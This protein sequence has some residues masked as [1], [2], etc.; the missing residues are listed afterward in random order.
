MVPLNA[1]EILRQ[2]ATQ[3]GFDAFG[4]AP[5]QA[6]AHAGGLRDWLSRSFQG[7][8]T[9]MARNPEIRADPAKY[10][11]SARTI[12]VAGVSSRQTTPPL[13]RGRIAAYAQG[14]DYHDFL[15]EK[16]GLLVHDTITAWGGNHRLCVDTS[17]LLEKPLAA[18]AGLGWQGKNTLL[19][20]QEH[21]PWLLLGIV[22]TDLAIAADAPA[23]D[24]YDT[25]TRCLDA[26]PTRAFPRPYVLDARRCLAYLTIEH[27]GSIPEEFR[28]LLGDRLF[29]CDECLEVCPWNRHAR[30]AR[31]IKL[32]PRPRPDLCDMLAWDDARFRS[33]FRGTPVF[34]LKR[35]RW[36]RNVSVVLGNIGTNA[37]LPALEKAAGD[38]DPLVREHA[39]WAVHRIRSRG[40]AD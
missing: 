1:G 13:R 3:L 33:E 28:P 5:A 29:G 38:D 10:D 34:R 40:S 37:D 17:P 22:L 24:H 21:G 7:E 27:P 8:M 4:I 14:A 20:H 9:W 23:S 16:L 19:I 26:C 18:L 30:N 6:P 25:C 39:T 12:L 32:T 2:T 31:E 35:N 15:R 11:P 36:L